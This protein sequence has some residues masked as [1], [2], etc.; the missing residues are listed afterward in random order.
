[1][2]PVQ[3]MTRI[4]VLCVRVFKS[5]SAIDEK[6]KYKVF[7]AKEGKKIAT[8]FEQKKNANSITA[9]RHLPIIQM[10]FFSP[11]LLSAERIKCKFTVPRMR[12][13]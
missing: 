13:A 9:R 8:L 11:T 2:F 6:K 1:M 12:S 10:N 3:L 4:A 7:A 5:Q